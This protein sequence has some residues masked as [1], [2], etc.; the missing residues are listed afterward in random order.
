MADAD[1]AITAGSGTKIDTRTVG[2]GTDEH[3]QVMVL[4]DPTTAAN[5]AVIGSGGQI[6]NQGYQPAA[7]AFSAVTTATNLAATAASGYNIAT[8]TLRTFTGT[9]PS[10]TFKLQA[11]DDNTNWTDL[12][13]I[14]NATGVVASLWTQSSA[15]AAGTAGPSIDYAVGGYTHVRIVTTAISGASA[16][17]AFGLGLQSMAYEPSPGIASFPTTATAP[18]LVSVAGAAA[19]TTLRAANPM[20]KA[21]YIYNDSTALLYI[22]L[23]AT[24]STSAYT[25]KVQPDGYYELPSPVYTGLVTGIWASATGNARVTE[26]L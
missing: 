19:S 13:G 10:V 18:T 26:V 9:T 6:Y 4:G 20:R 24:A 11:S 16:T 2:A 17:A 8:L 21:L 1:V 3:R 7:S 5:V 22:A 25:V 15:L 14:S 12:Q 23:A